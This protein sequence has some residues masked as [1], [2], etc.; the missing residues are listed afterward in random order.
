MIVGEVQDRV[1][2]DV[3]AAA[4]FN[5]IDV[6]PQHG[7]IPDTGFVTESDIAHHHGGL[8]EVDIAPQYR[9]LAE[10]AFELRDQGFHGGFGVTEIEDQRMAAD[11][12]WARWRR[13]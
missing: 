9:A 12:S 1:V 8:C 2:L 5:A 6:T 3:G 7:P 13:A 4:N 10:M 11:A